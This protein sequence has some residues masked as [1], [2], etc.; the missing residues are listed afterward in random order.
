[1]IEF[2]E[3]RANICFGGKKRK[4][5]FVTARRGVYTLEMNV[6]GVD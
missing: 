5:M 6:K 1:V 4:T 2:P 3:K